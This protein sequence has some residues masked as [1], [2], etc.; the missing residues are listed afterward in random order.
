MNKIINLSHIAMSLMA[1]TAIVS[2]PANAGPFDPVVEK[3]EI[4]SSMAPANFSVKNVAKLK[5]VKHRDLRAFGADPS[6]VLKG[7]VQCNPDAALVATQG[8]IGPVSV[9]VGATAIDASNAWA[10]TEKKDMSYAGTTEAWP[11]LPML[12]DIRRSYEGP[13]DIG[14]LNPARE[15]EQHLKA[16]VDNGG[17]AA[18][19]LNTGDAYDVMVPITLAGWCWMNPSSDNEHAGKTIVK[20]ATVEVP[21][22][23]LWSGDSQIVGGIGATASIVGGQNGLLAPAKPKPTRPTKPRRPV[24]VD[25]IPATPIEPQ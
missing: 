18:A 19:Y 5:T 20:T 7:H 11:Q 15:V 24:P 17:S 6:F 10:K 1:A 12:L 9:N 13:G 22:S 16:Y 2:A 21:A 23:I 25:P 8:F 4:L 3:V 14:G